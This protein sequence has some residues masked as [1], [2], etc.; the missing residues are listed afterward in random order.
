MDELVGDQIGIPSRQV[1][2]LPNAVAAE[3]VDL[4]TQDYPGDPDL[5]LFVGKIE[6]RKGVTSLVEGI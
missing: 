5:F 1:L 4:Q 6:F 3:S 2:Q